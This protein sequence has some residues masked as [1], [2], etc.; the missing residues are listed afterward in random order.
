MRPYGEAMIGA[1]FVDSINVQFAAPFSN[2]IFNSTDFYDAAAAFTWR[3]NFG[4]LYR[5]TDTL[6]LSAALGL[7]HVGGLSQVDQFVGTGLDD[8]N[9]D[10]ARLTFPI[11]IGLRLHFK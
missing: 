4:L 10:T 3:I 8:I 1:A 5:V 6:D 9:N 2:L 11:Q 7:R